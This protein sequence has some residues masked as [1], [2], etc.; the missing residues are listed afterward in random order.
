LGGG[1]GAAAKT[2]EKTNIRSQEAGSFHQEDVSSSFAI[3]SMIGA[4][5]DSSTASRD[6]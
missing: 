4:E 6:D 3:W 5:R 1:A 2:I